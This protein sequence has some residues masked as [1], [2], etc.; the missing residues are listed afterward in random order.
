MPS[1]PEFTAMSADD[2]TYFTTGDG[3]QLAYRDSGG[4]GVPL[5][6]LH[7]LGQSQ[8]A[9]TGQFE[10]LREHRRVV[11]LDFRGHGRSD[12]PGYGYRI[13]R[14]AADV[15][16]LLS[17]LGI[18]RV[19]ALGWSMGA[20]VWWSHIDLF[21]TSRIRRLVI[22]DEPVMIV[23]VP[24]L[25]AAEQEDLGALWNVETLVHI[26]AGQLGAEPD[27]INVGSLRWSYT[28]DVDP[29]VLD[30]LVTEMRIASPH[31]VGTLLLDHS[32]QNWSDVLPRIDVPT[33][34]I[35]AEGSHVTAHSQRSLAQAIPGAAVHIFPADVASSHFPF[36]Q[37]PAA[38]DTVLEP[39]LH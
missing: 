32:V 29:A 37:N 6:M 21:G 26:L 36:L 9:F 25:T 30:L 10:V 22:V 35:G 12:V 18:D 20:S 24:W 31:A 15:S 5:V 1:V 34:V 17:H 16:D 7:G 8:R 38:F 23:Q 19:D 28:G 3:V 13:A 27:P 4:P 39:F 14:L 2:V 11:T 33:L